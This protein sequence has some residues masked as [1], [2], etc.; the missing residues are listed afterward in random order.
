MLDNNLIKKKEV[1]T[2]SCW[3]YPCLPRSFLVSL[4]PCV[5]PVL[6]E[7]AEKAMGLGL[8][9]ILI[10][11]SVLVPISWLALLAYSF[12]CL[13]FSEPLFCAVSHAEPGDEE[14]GPS[15]LPSRSPCF[16][17]CICSAPDKNTAAYTKLQTTAMF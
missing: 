16:R 17:C 1:Q 15:I 4:S 13:K 8:W 14:A 5:Q 10:S 3:S 12:L 11:F 2:Q 6:R 9:L 7:V